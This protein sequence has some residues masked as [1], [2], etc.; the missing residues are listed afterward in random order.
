MVVGGAVRAEVV[1]DV[2]SSKPARLV[3]SRC[4]REPR[5]A[6]Q[7][8]E[9]TGIPIAS[10]YRT[11]H[12]LVDKGML[13]VER[14]AMTPD[15]KAYDLYRSRLRQAELEMV[16]GHI[17]ISWEVFEPVEDRLMNLWRRLGES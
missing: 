12:D 9:A 11:I 6:K 10:A 8:S 5:A 7:I 4:I 17:R 1:A 13:V 14:S 2:L 16:A 15:G 3:L